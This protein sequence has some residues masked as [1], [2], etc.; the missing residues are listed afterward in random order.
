MGVPEV[1]REGIAPSGRL[2]GAIQNLMPQLPNP[3]HEMVAQSRAGGATV[4]Q[5]YIDGGYK[6]QPATASKLCARPEIRARVQEIIDERAEMAAK[7]R[8]VA[9]KET[10]MDRAWWDNHL[11]VAILG[12]LRGDPVRD[13]T[14]KRLR[15]PETGEFIYKPDRAAALKGLELHARAQGWLVERTEIGGP[16]DFARLGEDELDQQILETAQ[17]LGL[18]ADIKLLEY[19]R[20]PDGETA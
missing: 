1:L 13:R 5:A 14:G 17:A 7:A 9:A 15:D 11:K 18:P 20:Q 19:F 16:G 2:I 10:G 6:Y 3:K 12:G 8:T 4:K